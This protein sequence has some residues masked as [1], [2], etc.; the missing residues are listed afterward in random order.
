MQQWVGMLQLLG[1]IVE[2]DTGWGPEY[3]MSIESR[4]IPFD[5]ESLRKLFEDRIVRG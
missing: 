1:I 2:K 3:G 4:V 5:I